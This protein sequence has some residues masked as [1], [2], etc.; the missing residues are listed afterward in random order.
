MG[1]FR[2]FATTVAMAKEKR[3][4]DRMNERRK[5]KESN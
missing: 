5:E 2:T 3:N 1:F 4:K